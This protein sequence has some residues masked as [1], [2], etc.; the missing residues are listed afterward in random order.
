MLGRLMCWFGW[1][2]WY[3]TVRVDFNGHTVD[4][5]TD[6]TR[7]TATKNSDG[8]I[9]WRWIPNYAVPPGDTIIEAMA[10]KAIP[11]MLSV[12]S[13]HTESYIKDVLQ[14]C[15]P[16]TPALARAIEK[17]TAGGDEAFWLRLE[18]N[19]QAD[20]ERLGMER[21]KQERSNGCLNYSGSL[22]YSE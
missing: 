13:G 6:C 17:F 21:P 8:S 15:E 12:E 3:T 14:G 4:K 5:S 20:L 2:E 1:H 7:C 16:I 10:L 11:P 19:Y 22:P 9:V 18:A